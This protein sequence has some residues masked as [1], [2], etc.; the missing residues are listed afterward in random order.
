VAWCLSSTCCRSGW[1]AGSPSIDMGCCSSPSR[2]RSEWIKAATSASI[3][4]AAI[5]SPT[6]IVPAAF[7]RGGSNQT[8]G[9]GDG[10]QGSGGG[11]V[12]RGRYAAEHGLR[13]R[14]RGGQRQH[15]CD[16]SGRRVDRWWR[17]NRPRWDRRRR[18][19]KRN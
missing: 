14:R 5:P 17:P 19:G 18:W 3:V 13:R 15:R 16:G 10:V 2:C 12:C 6:S 9:C 4:P 7:V 11:T 1:S 8:T